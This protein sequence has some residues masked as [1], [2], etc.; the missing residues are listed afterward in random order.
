MEQQQP[1]TGRTQITGPTTWKR[2]PVVRFSLSFFI[3]IF[4]WPCMQMS[5]AAGSFA[6]RLCLWHQEIGGKKEEE[7][8]SMQIHSPLFFFV[9]GRK[10]CNSIR[11]K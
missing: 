9:C 10:N 1:L 7:E 6:Y 11:F 5:Q 8:G 4:P 2:W 3:I